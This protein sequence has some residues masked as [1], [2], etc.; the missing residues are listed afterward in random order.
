MH[1][2][3]V[4]LEVFDVSTRMVVGDGETALFWMDKWLDGTTIKDIAL[5][6]SAMIPKRTRTRRTVREAS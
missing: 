2:S 3:Y 4:N 6:L 1:F 5:D